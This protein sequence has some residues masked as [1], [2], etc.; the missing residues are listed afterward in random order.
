MTGSGIF[1]SQRLFAS[2]ATPHSMSG[3]SSTLPHGQLVTVDSQ[4]SASECSRGQVQHLPHLP[5]NLQDMTA[6]QLRKF[7]VTHQQ[8]WLQ[9]V[10]SSDDGHPFNGVR[11]KKQLAGRQRARQVRYWKA[12][13]L[14]QKAKSDQQI[15][16]L[17]QDAS[18]YVE[19]KRRKSTSFRRKLTTFG[20]YKVALARNISS[21]SCSSTLVVLNA[22]E[23]DRTSVA[24]PGLS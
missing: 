20:G 6:A 7:I 12:K 4:A 14:K 23:T 15:A 24:R 9:L 5:N 18:L 19:S 11:P 13:A 1:V 17:K 21:S 2:P 8:T 3:E 16:A 22:D 10:A